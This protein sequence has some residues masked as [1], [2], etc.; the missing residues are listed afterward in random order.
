[1][2][3]SNV[4]TKV[5]TIFASSALPTD[6]TNPIPNAAQS[7]GLAS[8]PTGFQP[9]NFTQVAAG[10]VPPWG[11]DINGLFLVLSAWAQWQAAGGPIFYDST[12]A[13][14]IGGY[15]KGTIVQST[16]Y[17]ELFWLCSADNN[18][19]NPDTGGANWLPLSFNVSRG[20]QAFSISST[21]TVPSGVSSVYAR[22]WGAG[23]G[24]GGCTTNAGAGSGGGGGEYREGALS[25]LPGQT[26]TIVVGS[27]GAGGA[28]GVNGTAGT[29]SS[30][31]VPSG[32]QIISNPGTG[33]FRSTG[34]VAV[35]SVGQGGSGGSGGFAIGGTSGSF[36]IGP[37]QDGTYL[38]GL[39]GPAYSTS[40][41]TPNQGSIGHFG[42]F[43]GGGGSGSSAND[44]GGAGAPGFCVL[45]W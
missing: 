23:G 39:G 45:N 17:S 13:A 33:G 20:T 32:S 41:S 27:G 10:G 42:A 31:T 26:V 3:Q 25:V 1:M 21:F 11:K 37:F 15:P 6:V 36:G 35:G 2:Q 43:P 18:S 5:P 24:G 7:G 34:G 8:W 14:N 12:F 16:T 40:I 22:V 19:S 30:V 9:I 28:A 29:L 38:G 4:P 44:S